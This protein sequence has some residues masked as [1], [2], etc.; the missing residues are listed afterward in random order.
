VRVLLLHNYYRQPGGEDVVVAQERALLESK[1]HEVRL[2]AVHN[3]AINGVVERC[4][5]ALSS[6]YSAQSKKQVEREVQSFQ[7]DIAHVQNFFPLLSP[8]VYD[9]CQ[10]NGVPVV[11]TLHNFRLIC[12][13]G[14]LFREG[15]PCELC[16]GKRVPWPAIQ[17]ACYRNGRTGSAAIAA[18]LAV[19]RH[20]GTWT[21]AVDA[22]ITLSNFARQK[23]IAGKL[24]S[25][26]LFVKPNFL[27]PDPGWRRQPGDCALFV[28]RL[29]PEKGIGTLLS[30]W[31]RTARN[32][33]LRIVGTGPLEQSVRKAARDSSIKLLGFQTQESVLELMEDA[34]FVI[35]PSECFEGFPRVLVESFAKGKPVVSSRLGSLAELVDHGRTGLLFEPGDPQALA[36]AIEWMFTHPT[37]LHQMSHAARHEFESKYTADRNYE[38]LMRIYARVAET[39]RPHAAVAC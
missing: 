22:Y 38:Q 24:P 6:I 9:A 3:D 36:D 1:G 21:S 16:V 28:G 34:A 7:P 11:Q 27:F 18:M 15:K 2:L 33:E 19:H 32:R 30:A 4:K 37:E 14:L 35:F 39:R 5:A 31:A 17:H 25:D 12:P 20:R 10:A 29:S 13:S 26:R 8:S 23:L